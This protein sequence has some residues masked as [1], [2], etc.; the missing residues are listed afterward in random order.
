MFLEENA[1]E[2]A[3]MGVGGLAYDEMEGGV[4]RQSTVMMNDPAM[5]SGQDKPQQ[6]TVPSKPLSQSADF[7]KEMLKAKMR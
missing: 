4:M 7:Y 5:M 1:S 3:G 6:E 2:L